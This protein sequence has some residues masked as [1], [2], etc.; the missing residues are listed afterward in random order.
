MPGP[1]RSVPHA[2]PARLPR[3]GRTLLA[4]AATAALGAS[5]GGVALPAAAQGGGPAAAAAPRA[6]P[7][8]PA[9][10]LPQARSQGARAIELLGDRLPEVAA[11]Y[12]K[13][14]DEFRALLLNDRRL[15]IDRHGRLFVEDELD[16]PLPADAPGAAASGSLDG[17]LAPLDQ[18][19]LLHSR[20][21]ARRTVYLNFRGAMLSNTAWNG[22]SGT[23]TAP[24]FDLDGVPYANSTAELQ[25]IQYIWQRVAEDYA[26]FDVDVTTEPPPADAL[27]RSGSTDATFGST[28][29]ITTKAGVYDCSCGGVA[30]IGIF[31]DSDYYKP[32]L[33]FYDALGSG[34]E[35]YVAEALSHEAGHNMGLQHD[36]H[37]GGGYYDGQGSGAT[38]WAPIM[39]VGYY[40]ALV[41]WSKGEYA[42]ANNTQDDYVVMGQNGLPLRADDHAG[43]V[44]G[45][46]RLA[47]T[48]AGATS[49][50]AGD[51]VVERPGDVDTFSFDAA[52][53]AATL[54]VAPAVRSGNVDLK[55]ELRNAAGSVMA[56]ANAA[57]TLDAT[58]STTL[59]TA[60]SY[61]LA[62]TGVGKGDPL[63]TGYTAYGSTG[64]YA[65]SGSVAAS[66]AGQPP[67]AVLSA[68]PT[69]G[70]VPLTV[71]F[72]AAGSADPDGSIVGYAWTF[73]DGSSAS[74]ASVSHTYQSAGSFSAS[75][76][77]T[78][79]SGLSATRSTT[80][81]VAPV[82]SALPMR[83]TDIGLSLS[84]A[85]G[86][87]ARAI[88]A[89]ALR[90]GN[91]QPVIGATV[92]GR[93]SGIVSGTVSGS[94]GS[95]GV[96]RL[97]SP[98]TR[99][100]GTFTFSVTGV[101]LDG[102]TYA[103]S[104]NVETSDSITR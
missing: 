22:S 15:R 101:A 4:W 77:V 29:L 64:Q 96:V 87:K 85:K 79:D 73:G 82:V 63:T 14:P 23:I 75:L 13:S 68:T 83:V 10:R 58:I 8:F 86:G 71:A 57:D 17:T 24:P 46:T 32:A 7:P 3:P 99:S 39:G 37:S 60:G 91:G 33:V 40:Q 90:D 67:S 55:L 80:I 21:G 93:W 74:G 18:T 30:Y 104:T 54:R 94:T 35:K 28:V 65:V 34:N 44:A 19:Y 11:W 89:V 27:T 48:A 38:G 36:G 92:S 69:S 98:L 84:S 88:A 102:Y 59:A 72:S 100:G 42:T 6:K 103:P 56:S 50:L 25:R 51:G 52:A 70:T 47:A 53:G 26:P 9:L 1:V 76:R 62:V 2:P 41:Q 31:D 20:P 95:D 78:D 16:Q 81:T 97:N 5:I 45:A 66:T 43:T 49:T 12:G 61:V